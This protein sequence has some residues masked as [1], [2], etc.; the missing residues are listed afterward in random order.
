VE[1][2]LGEDGK[3]VPL[4]TTESRLIDACASLE[5][6]VEA[7]DGMRETILAS[8]SLVS[9]SRRSRRMRQSR[10]KLVQGSE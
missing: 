3:Y 8:R 5:D 1:W 6:L 4:T 9:D 10:L 7:F 2:L